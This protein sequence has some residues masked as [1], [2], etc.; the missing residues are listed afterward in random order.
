MTRLYLIRHG[1]TIWNNESK[2]QGHSDVPLAESG[3]QQAQLAAAWLQKEKLA[4]VYASD[5]NRAFETA[6]IIA[7]THDL[8][9]ISIPALREMNFGVWEGLTF[10]Q[11]KENYADLVEIWSTTPEKLLI[12]DGESFDQLKA[13]AHRALMELVARH[14]EEN[15]V[16]V[17]HGGTIRTL[18][19]AV[20]DLPLN[21]IWQFRQDNTAVNIIDFYGK[22]AILSLLNSTAHLEQQSAEPV[23][24]SATDL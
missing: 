14:P 21:R 16:V 10:N 13:R 17:S 1:V 23:A 3:R 2:Y 8:A 5:L 15:I 18:I 6:Q 12:P 22:K 19:C 20:L 9:V 24:G 11:I 7:A 4:A